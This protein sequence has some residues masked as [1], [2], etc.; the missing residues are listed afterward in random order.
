LVADDVFPDLDR[1]KMA[2]IA[3]DTTIGGSVN[4]AQINYRNVNQ[5]F[6][7]PYVPSLIT[8]S[9]GTGPIF[10]KIPKSAW[11]WNLLEWYVSA[12]TRA[13]PLCMG[14]EN[15]PLLGGVPLINLINTDQNLSSDFS[16]RKAY[17]IDE[18][19][20]EQLLTNGIP[21]YRQQQPPPAP[22]GTY[23]YYVAADDLADYC[24]KYGFSSYNFDTV[25]DVVTPTIRYENRSYSA[26]EK[27]QV[28]SYINSFSFGPSVSKLLYRSIRFV[29]FGS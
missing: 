7:L 13:I 19:E 1:P 2:G 24:K 17:V 11:L 29:E 21:A 12:W 22:V 10:H 9:G 15:A 25:N 6:N 18:F 27:D 4:I 16:G 23:D 26:G 28:A 20:Y 14:N 8:Q 3:G 5:Y